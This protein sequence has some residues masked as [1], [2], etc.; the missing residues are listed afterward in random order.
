M[1]ELLPEFEKEAPLDAKVTK[2]A[3]YFFT[4]KGKFKLPITPPFLRDHGNY[5]ISLS[6]FVKWL[7]SQVAATGI[8]VFTGFAGP[9][10]V[11]S[12]D[13]GPGVRTDGDGGDKEGE[14]KLHLRLGGDL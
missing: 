2:E 3:V 14:P 7:G 8:T 11:F 6:K 10:L 1:L 13:R 9:G 4:E 5:V 12:G